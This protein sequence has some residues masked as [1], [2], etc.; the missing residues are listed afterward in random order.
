MAR[1]PKEWV[2]VGQQSGRGLTIHVPKGE[3]E[4][5]PIDLDRPIQAKR[6]GVN[7]NGRAKVILTLRNKAD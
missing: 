5:L 7:D 3:I 1:E 2:E 4:E 6:N